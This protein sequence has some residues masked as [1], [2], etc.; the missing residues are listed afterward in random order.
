[1]R[2]IVDVR[3]MLEIERGVDLRRGD[4]GVAEQFLHGAQIAARLQHV[5]GERMPQ[6]VRMHVGGNAGDQ[7]R[8]LHTIAHDIRRQ[9]IAARREKQRIRIVLHHLVTDGEPGAQ[10]FQR[11]A[12]DRHDAA[13]IALAEHFD[14]GGIELE[15]AGRAVAV[16]IGETGVEA[17][18]F[19]ES[20]ARRVEQFEDGVI[21]QT[22]GRCGW[23][24]FH[25]TRGVV[26]G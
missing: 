17:D 6:H 7:R 18:E 26:D 22:F 14:L 8:A 20:Q 15:P 19:R 13:P 1:M 3:E 2:L 21:A 16:S 12:A 10:G 4:A 23:R 5:R 25:Q 24:A 9:A 11:L